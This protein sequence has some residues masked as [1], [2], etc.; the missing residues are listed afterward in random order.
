[1]RQS[2]G[3]SYAAVRLPD[4]ADYVMRP[5][6]RGLCRYES[7]VDGTLGLE[8]IAA[9]NDAIDAQDENAYRAQ[10]ASRSK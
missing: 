2:S 6:I 4:G 7:V 10:E 3:P 9:M 8:D 1:M 5:V